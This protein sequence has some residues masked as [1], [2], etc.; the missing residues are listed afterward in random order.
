M[1]WFEVKDVGVC[2]NASEMEE[3]AEHLYEWEKSSEH[4][5]IYKA[6]DKLEG[7]T[8]HCPHCDKDVIL[9]D[10][11]TDVCPNCGEVITACSLC[12]VSS[13]TK[14]GDCGNGLNFRSY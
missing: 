4:A 11:P 12:C 14:C 1:K 7:S 13:R 2:F 10:T 9:S 8:E 5:P 6:V 3:G